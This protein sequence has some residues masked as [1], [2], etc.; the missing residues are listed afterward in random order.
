MLRSLAQLLEGLDGCSSL[1]QYRNA[2][3][4]IL[5]IIERCSYTPLIANATSRRIVEQMA[6]SAFIPL[7]TLRLVE[8]IALAHKLSANENSDMFHLAITASQRAVDHIGHE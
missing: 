1:G 7:V 8:P 2:H 4:S 6:C 3:D 5:R